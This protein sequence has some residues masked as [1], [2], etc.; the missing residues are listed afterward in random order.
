MKIR[1]FQKLYHEQKIKKR[2]LIPVHAVPMTKMSDKD[3]NSL[4]RTILFFFEYYG[5]K[6]WRQRSEGRF[7][8]GQQVTNVIGQVITV[9]KSKFIPQG[10]SGGI[11]A[12]D[13]KAVIPPLGRSM[14]IEVKIGRDRQRESQKAY[15][16]EIEGMGGIYILVR[17]WEDFY[18][19]VTKHLPK[20]L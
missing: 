16:S 14:D 18:I 17:S 4:T 10:N 1:E 11:G 3:A 13:I 15:Q 2:P 8:P 20:N 12:G 6:A 19:Q 9:R 5:I 7:I